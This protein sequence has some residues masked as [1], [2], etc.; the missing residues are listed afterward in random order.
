MNDLFKETAIEGCFTF[1]NSLFQDQRGS[2]TKMYSSEIFKSLGLNIPV[3]EVFF[4]N[5]H[6][7]VV[8]GM[9]FQTP[10]HDHAKIVSCISGR[11]LD[12]VLDLRKSS[13]SYGQAIGMELTALNETTLFI[14]KGCAH[15]FYTYED[16]SIICY[17]V[18]TH[19]H[20]DSDQG[21]LWNSFGFKWP[22]EQVILSNRDLQFPKFQDFVNPFK[23]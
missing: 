16:N 6:K 19:H 10:P 12:V 5:S 18:E 20:K 9:H 11:V 17:I 22:G 7:N 2:F 4:S 1:K 21:V 15:G 23:G 13:P 8:R 3:A 14:P